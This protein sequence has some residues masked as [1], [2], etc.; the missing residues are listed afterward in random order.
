[1][2]T[3]LHLPPALTQSFSVV[4]RDIES[5][6]DGDPLPDV[7]EPLDVL[8]PVDGLVLGLADGEPTPDEPLPVLEDPVPLGA[9]VPLVEPEPTPVPDELPVLPVPELPAPAAP[10]AV[11]PPAV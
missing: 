8:S 3:E 7:P 6:V 11:P 4:R 10:P 5:P 2:V 1:M 9:P